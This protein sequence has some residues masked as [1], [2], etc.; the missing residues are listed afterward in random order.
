ML[1][2]IIVIGLFGGCSSMPGGSGAFVAEPSPIDQRIDAA[3]IEDYILAL[4]PYAFHEE[5]VEQFTERVRHA[6][7]TLKE[8]VGKSSDYLFVGG[9][10]SSPSKEFTLNR[11]ARTLE[12][13][14]FNWEPGLQDD[15]V[16]WR[17]VS[18]GWLREP[19]T[20]MSDAE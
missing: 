18:G 6:R 15:A 1:V 12:I 13:R 10:G 4:P 11:D 9:D 19:H 3:S 2:A 14:N 7:T 16:T 8:N 5:S 20:I 17:R